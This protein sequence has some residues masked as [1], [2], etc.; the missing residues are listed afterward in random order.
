M[1]WSC[2]WAGPSLRRKAPDEKFRWSGRWDLH[3]IW[4]KV[5]RLGAEKKMMCQ[6]AILRRKPW[7]NDIQLPQTCEWILH[8]PS[9]RSRWSPW[10][11][12]RLA[13]VHHLHR[14]LT[15]VDSW[16]SWKGRAWNH[17]RLP[18]SEEATQHFGR[19]CGRDARFETAVQP[20]CWTALLRQRVRICVWGGAWRENKRYWLTLSLSVELK[21]CGAV[22]SGANEAIFIKSSRNY[23]KWPNLTT[24]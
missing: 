16:P 9:V 6:L 18:R 12:A 7:I 13:R 21:T 22:R 5:C 3:R 4:G 10:T 1:T 15:A 19:T 24:F 2:T 14:G 20:W 23:N 8:R 17:G 11:L